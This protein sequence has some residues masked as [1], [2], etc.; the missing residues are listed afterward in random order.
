MIYWSEAS[1]SVV[2]ANIGAV[3]HQLLRASFVSLVE[4]WL[5]LGTRRCPDPTVAG[6]GSATSSR[7]A[8]RGR[9]ENGNRYCMWSDQRSKDAGYHHAVLTKIPGRRRK[10]Y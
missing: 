5:R 10:K 3:T 7:S 1:G 9:F 4:D 2:S 8:A 6:I